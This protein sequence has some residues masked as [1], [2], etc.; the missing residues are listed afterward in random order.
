MAG[1][2]AHCVTLAEI[3]F[4]VFQKQSKSSHQDEGDTNSTGRGSL[5]LKRTIFTRSM[6][7]PNVL[8]S[9]PYDISIDPPLSGIFAFVDQV[10]EMACKMFQA[11]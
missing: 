7:L 3:G 1:H 5:E 6:K 8:K 11:A 4:L 2:A 9:G 10:A